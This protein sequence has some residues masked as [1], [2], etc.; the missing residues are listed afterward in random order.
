MSEKW[1]EIQSFLS[2]QELLTSI[3]DLSIAIKQ[4]GAGLLR[5]ERAERAERARERLRKFLLELQGVLCKRGQNGALGVDPRFRQLADDFEAARGDSGHF[6]S[7]IMREGIGKALELLDCGD[8]KSMQGLLESL[9]DLRRVIS[10]HQ[11]A[12]TAAI[13]EDF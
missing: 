2:D 10:T 3:N 9:S 1:L 8:L 4:E 13:F 5:R 12:D 11:Q 6:T 7:T